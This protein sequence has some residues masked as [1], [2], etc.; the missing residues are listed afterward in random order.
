MVE[1]VVLRFCRDLQDLAQARPELAEKSADLERQLH[2][3][4]AF[5]SGEETRGDDVPF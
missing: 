4:A 1:P 5:W 3:F 2:E